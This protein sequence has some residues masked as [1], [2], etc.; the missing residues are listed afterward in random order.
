MLGKAS[1]MSR[2]V[3][4]KFMFDPSVVVCLNNKREVS[5]GSDWGS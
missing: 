2:W 5:V 4:L 3:E 1:L